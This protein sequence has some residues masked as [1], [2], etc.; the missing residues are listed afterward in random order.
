MCASSEAL[1]IRPAPEPAD[2][3]P[4]PKGGRRR[5]RPPH[6]QRRVADRGV[7]QALRPIRRRAAWWPRLGELA[8][9]DLNEVA[10]RSVP[11]EDGRGALSDAPLIVRAEVISPLDPGPA[12]EVLEVAEDLR[13]GRIGADVPQGVDEDRGGVPG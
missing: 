8:R 3:Q 4:A 9:V 11:A 10:P 13:G 6:V 12:P 2:R 7:V 1:Q 5:R